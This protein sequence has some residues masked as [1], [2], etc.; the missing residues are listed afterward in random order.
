[1]L[2]VLDL[3]LGDKHLEKSRWRH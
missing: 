1:M 3:N 2:V